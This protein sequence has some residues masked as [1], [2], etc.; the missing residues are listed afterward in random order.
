MGES[1]P[2]SWLTS[3]AQKYGITGVY[4]PG[5]ANFIKIR[6]FDVLPSICYEDCFPLFNWGQLKKKPDF[7]IN[8]TN[9]GWFFPS[10]LAK[11]HAGLSRLRVLEIGVPMIRVC[12]QAESGWI[13]ADGT[14]FLFDEKNV[15]LPVLE[16]SLENE[17]KYYFLMKEKW[18]F[19]GI[20]LFL[21]FKVKGIFNRLRFKL[22]QKRKL[23]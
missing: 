20:F 12:E 8:I 23:V 10:S 3:L 9:D 18:L 15:L 21:V 6:E 22:A 19:F 13:R 2:F 4:H 14:S 7:M 1:I 16:V 17:Q 5:K 11:V